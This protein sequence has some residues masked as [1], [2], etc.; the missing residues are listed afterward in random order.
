MIPTYNSTA[1][2]EGT[3]LRVVNQ[4]PG[5]AHMQI[6]IVDDGSED[7]SAYQVL[8]KLNLTDRIQY[9]RQAKNVGLSANWNTC[10]KRAQ[11][12]IIHILHQD[13]LI[14]PGFYSAMENAFLQEPSI[15]AAF[16]RHNFIDERDNLYGTSPLEQ[17][18]AGIIPGWMDRI[19]LWERIQTPSITVR[20]SVYERLG[21]FHPSLAFVLDWEMWIRISSAYPLW[22]EPRILA[23]Y[24]IHSN[25]ETQRLISY[26]ENIRDMQVFYKVLKSYLPSNLLQQSENLSRRIHARRAFNLAM[27]QLGKRSFYS[28]LMLIYQGMRLK[29]DVHTIFYLFQEFTHVMI[30]RKVY[31]N[32]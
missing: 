2:L 24:R 4:D 6:E 23:A 25:S 7:D 17:D 21:G 30:W 19:I 11:G 10:I 8:H 5:P 1:Y 22:Y 31:P 13:D 18:T 14:E 32:K 29:L 20:R 15:G 28:A 3:L 12:E 16:C 9:Y 26:G 27:M